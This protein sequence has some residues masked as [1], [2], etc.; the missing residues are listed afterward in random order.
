[1]GLDGG[2]VDQHE[3][4][5]I[6]EFDKSCENLLP[7]PSFAP[8]IEAVEHRGVRPVFVRKRA[9]AAALAQAMEDA[10]DNT[11]VVLALGSGVD[12]RKMRLD[13]RP[14]CIVQPE[15]VRHD[16]SPPGQLESPLGN[17]FNWVQNLT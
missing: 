4:R 6:I 13:Q 11:S 16:S 3:R 8:A 7:Q 12:L 2:A 15:I 1:M 5:Q 9:P 10:A 14:L 17:Q